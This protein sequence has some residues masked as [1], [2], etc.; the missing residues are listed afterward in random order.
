MHKIHEAHSHVHGEG[1]GHTAI[2][3]GGQIGYLHDG[4]L[5]SPHGDH[6]D[7]HVIE[8]SAAN[9]DGCTPGHACGGHE[10]NHVH[11]EG[12]GHERV[13]HG[14]HV[15]YLVDGHL[16]HVHSGH[17]DDHGKIEMA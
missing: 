5:H 16:H 9:P 1:C 7:E 17:C 10:A 6:Y 4:C 12:C 11:G 14:D 3:H 2:K 8:V 13:P 15:D